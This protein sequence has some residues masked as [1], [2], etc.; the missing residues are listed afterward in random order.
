MRCQKQPETY[1]RSNMAFG[2][3][4]ETMEEFCFVILIPVFNSSDTDNTYAGNF[5]CTS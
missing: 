1:V 2:K 3:I 4:Y 5:D